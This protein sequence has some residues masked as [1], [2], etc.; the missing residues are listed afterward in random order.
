MSDHRGLNLWDLGAVLP[1]Q[2]LTVRQ[3]VLLYKVSKCGS[4]I[5]YLL[6]VRSLRGRRLGRK[7]WALSCLL[8]GLRRPATIDDITLDMSSRHTMQC[9]IYS[10]THEV[11]CYVKGESCGESYHSK[12]KSY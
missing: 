9:C 4:G 12:M 2:T 7:T 5:L 6:P 3:A 10:P 8:D 11:K 1:G